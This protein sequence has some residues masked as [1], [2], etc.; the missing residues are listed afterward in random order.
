MIDSEAALNLI[1]KNIIEKY[2]LPTQPCNPPIK[3]KAI[4][5]TLIGEGI[6]QQTQTLTLNV[7]LFHQESNSLYFVNSSRH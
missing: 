3:I 7:G 4:D 6:T 5:D 2:N 1:S